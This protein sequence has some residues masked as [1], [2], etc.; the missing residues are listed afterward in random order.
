MV[1]LIVTNK[2]TTKYAYYNST[3]Q[4][5][6]SMYNILILVLTNYVQVSIAHNLYIFVGEQNLGPYSGLKYHIS[7]TIRPRRGNHREPL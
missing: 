3:L 7:S 1:L 4:L 2:L 5:T 6:M